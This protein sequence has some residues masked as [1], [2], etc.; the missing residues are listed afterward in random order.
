MADGTFFLHRIMIFTSIKIL[1]TIL[2]SRTVRRITSCAN[3]TIRTFLQRMPELPLMTFMIC[4]TAINRL[5]A[6]FTRSDMRGITSHTDFFALWAK[7]I[8]TAI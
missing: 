1:I 8:M 2:T 3:I 7:I 6:V 5:L 4:L